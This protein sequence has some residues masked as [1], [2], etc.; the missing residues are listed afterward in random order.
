MAT[1]PDRQGARAG[2]TPRSLAPSLPRLRP[3]CRVCSGAA[4]EERA[5][6]QLR[7]AG[8][9]LS[10]LSDVGRARPRGIEPRDNAAVGALCLAVD[11]DRQAAHGKPRVHRPPERQIEYRPRSIV[12]WRKIFRL[13]VEI[14]ILAFGR[15]LVIAFQRCREVARGD[16]QRVLGFVDGLVT[17]EELDQRHRGHLGVCF[18][19]DQVG[20]LVRL[21]QHERRRARVVGVLGD[22]PLALVVDDHA[23][24]QNF[25]RICRRGN[26]HLV[27]VLGDPSRRDTQPDAQPVIVGVAQDVGRDQAMV[28]TAPRLA[29]CGSVL[30]DHVGV[31]HET[32]G[33]DDD[34]FGLDRAG[35]GEV[36]PGDTDHRTIVVQDEGRCPGLVADLHA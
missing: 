28:L 23:G 10:V 9:S 20:G 6:A 17:I 11:S 18:V 26:E 2:L 35:F 33:R 25:W 34:R 36:L 12:L 19:D 13:L 1:R 30:G 15:E 16:F 27:H 4:A 32:A 22:E 21:L 8:V 29:Q 14:R 24:Q 3:R 31:H 5:L 7:A